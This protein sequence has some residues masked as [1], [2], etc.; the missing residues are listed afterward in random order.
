[1][2]EAF[3]AL[4]EKK[5]FA[6]IT[7]KEICQ[8][9]GVNRST[10]YLHYETMADLLSESAEYL[11]RQFLEDIGPDARDVERRLWDCPLEDLYLVTPQYLLPYL[12][13]IKAHRRLFRTALEHAAVLGM[14][15]IYQRLFCRIFTP[16]LTRYQVPEGDRHYLMTFYLCGLT[17]V[18]TE[19]L[20]GD[21]TDSIDHVMEI[22]QQCV[23]RNPPENTG[24]GTAEGT[25]Q[26]A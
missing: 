4:L 24:G 15:T 12:T 11:Y 17:A 9:A 18:V 6:Y 13:R 14:E 25:T 22:L 3:L 10:F 5:D 2:D 7:V 20:K 21:C 19:W 1:M 26:Q 8:R 16:I 23:A